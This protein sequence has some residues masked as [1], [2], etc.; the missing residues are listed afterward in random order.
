MPKIGET[1]LRLA[2]I[3]AHQ[4]V[5]DYVSVVARIE[6]LEIVAIADQDADAAR[7][8]S[9][10]LNAGSIERLFRNYDE[11]FDAVAIHSPL[12]LRARYICQA[13][14]TGKHVIVD[15]PVAA[16]VAEPDKVNAICE[17]ADI[18]FMVA[19]GLRSTPAAT[20]IR[21]RMNQGK[22]GIPG[23]VRVHHWTPMSKTLTDFVD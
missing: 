2:L 20:T 12:N 14:E 5:H 3:D 13:A 1:S 15:A 11:A 17:A 18:C 23:L 16:T 19:H 7:T 22:L 4:R 21:E 8:T 6:Q 9:E 10:T